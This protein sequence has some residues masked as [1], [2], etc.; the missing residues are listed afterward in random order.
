[1]NDTNSDSI[2]NTTKKLL[3]LEPDFTG[4]DQDI[5]VHI[6][7][8]L[9]ALTQMGVGPEDG[10]IVED[11]DTTYEDYLGEDIKSYQDIKTYIYYKV[12]LGFDPPASSTILNSI[13]DLLAEVE[14]RIWMKA[15]PP[16]QTGGE[17]SK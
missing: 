5:L 16:D 2:L 15:N 3:G 10:F 4:F 12:R 6:N 17:N 9:S 11:A 8:V 7:A 14:W 13:N 1:M